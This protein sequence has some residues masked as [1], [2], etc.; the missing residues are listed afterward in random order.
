MTW[1]RPLGRLAPDVLA[2]VAGALT[3]LAFA[4]FGGWPLAVLGPAALF[5]LLAG[6]APA[7]A[8]RLGWLYGIGLMGVGVFWVRVSIAQ[9]GGVEPWLAVV[10]AAGFALLMALY[11]GLLGWLG[12]RLAGRDATVA[13]LAVLP[14]GWVL[15]EWARGW[16]LTGFPWLALG[17]SQIDAPLGGLAPLLGV[18]GASLGATLTA[19]AIVL[20]LRP[21]LARAP[22][23]ALL[24]GIVGLWAL[25][26]AGGRISWSTPAGA[27]LTASV[28]QGNVEQQM[29]WRPETLAPTL[30]TYLDLSAQALASR[31]VVWPETAVP[32]FAHLVQEDLLLPLEAGFKEAGRD[33]LVGIPI[34]EDDGRYY[35]AMLALGASGRDAYYKRHLVPFGEFLPFE[36]VL[37]PVLG[38]LEIPMSD[39]SAGPR[40]E[41][42][43]LTLAGHSAGLSICYEDAFA[44]EVRDALPAA[45]FLVNASND[46]WFGDSLA[47]HQ[48]LEIARM[49]ARETERYLLRAT[50]TGISAIIGSRGEVVSRSRLF[51]QAVLTAQIVPLAGATPFVRFGNAAVVAI[52]LSLVLMGARAARGRSTA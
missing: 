8:F 28:V 33:L 35:N 46:A 26:F 20:L 10:I 3:V 38:F 42:P 41:P 39:F 36:P 25:A 27:P 7:T 31:L 51:E 12:A 11:Y 34:E 18:H 19:G 23:V 17:Y 15:A 6:R 43:L 32:A 9:F 29:K 50:N 16:V 14:G 1:L 49:R 47:P 22:R 30:K 2:L 44:A 40:G 13:L 52:A 48:H 4:P 21:G 45:A 5:H 37:G 24:A